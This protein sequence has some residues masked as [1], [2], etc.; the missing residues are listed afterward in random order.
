[1]ERQ[2]ITLSEKIK[3]NFRDRFAAN[4]LGLEVLRFWDGK[5]PFRFSSGMESPIYCDNRMILSHID[6][7]SFVV[8][9]FIDFLKNKLETIDA[10]AGVA[11][12]ALPLSAILAET[13]NRP[14]FYVRPSKKAHGLENKVEGD[15][16]ILK[17]LKVLVVE[18][19]ISTG[20]SSL[21]AVRS[22]K[23]SG[24]QVDEM[25]AIFSYQFPEAQEAFEEEG[26]NAEVILHYP[27]LL[28]YAVMKGYVEPGTQH[29]LKAWYRDPWGWWEKYRGEA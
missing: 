20:E 3:P 19:L 24:A 17:D 16:R 21:K 6:L 9:R 29:L 10:V 27:Y 4:L 22:L 11:T 25:I 2:K 23:E 26:V 14:Y 5:E 18:D 1:M 15:M 7:R 28:D 12:G 13:I 8:R